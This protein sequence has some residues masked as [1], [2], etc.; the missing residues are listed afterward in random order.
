MSIT[1]IMIFLGILGASLNTII[2]LGSIFKKR[3]V[4]KLDRSSNQEKLKLTVIVENEKG[5]KIVKENDSANKSD[6]DRLLRGIR[7]YSH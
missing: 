5:E 6:V 7:S 4:Q 2:L 3:K 1:F